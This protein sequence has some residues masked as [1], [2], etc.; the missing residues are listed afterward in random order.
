MKLT[1]TALDLAKLNI[2][3]HGA[4]ERGAPM[5]RKELKRHQVLDF[6]VKHVPAGT[7]VAME[8]CGS[9]HEWARRLQQLGYVPRLI[10]PQY[11]KA[12]VKT[13]KNDRAD[14]EAICEAACRPNM[15]FV[16]VK[17]VEQQ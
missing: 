6:F 9:A 13:N 16:A 14:A 8:A 7:V 5:L 10:A 2:Q 17:S 15:R 4:D 1:T 12:Y 3:F 11:V